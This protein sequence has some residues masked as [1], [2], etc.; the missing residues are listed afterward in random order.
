MAAVPKNSEINIWKVPKLTDSEFRIIKELI[1]AKVGICLSDHKKRLVISRL[2]KRLRQL[3]LGSFKKYFDLI[4]QDGEELQRAIDLLTTNET[5]FFREKNHFD[6][7][8]SQVFPQFDKFKEIKVWSAAS[9]TGEEAYS[10]A[11]VMAEYF[12]IGGRWRVFGTDVNEEV[13]LK[14]KEAIYPVRDKDNIPADYLKK[15]FLKGVRSKEG[16]VQVDSVLKHH[17][18]FDNLNLIEPWPPELPNFD[19][20]F[21]RNVMIYFDA[22]KKKQL[23]ERITEKI[24]MGGYFFVG[25]SETL[26]NLTEKFQLVAPSVYKRIK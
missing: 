10:I 20:V 1:Y 23:V 4:K 21:L 17:V 8:E 7:L 24:A 9:S 5:Y 25:Q 22:L 12:G 6:F 18:S 2:T 13:I 16:F 26:N 14:A 15:Y 3:Q 11:V 19:I